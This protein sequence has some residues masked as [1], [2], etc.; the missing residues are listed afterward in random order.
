MKTAQFRFN[1]EGVPGRFKSSKGWSPSTISR[2]LKNTKYIG[3]WIW[4]KTESRKDPKTGRLRRFPKP[5]SKWHIHKDENLRIIPQKLWDKV[6]KRLEKTRRT[7]PG[8]KN[9]RGFEGQNG[10]RVTHYPRELLSGA[11]VCAVCGGAIGK[12][13]G[14]AGG[15]YGCL[16]AGKGSCDNKLLV[17]RTVAERIIITALG[18]KLANTDNLSFV[19]KRVE[20]KVREM[21]SEV[22][23]KIHL[24]EIELSSEQRRVDN[25]VAYISEGRRSEAIAKALETVEKRVKELS[26]ELRI[27][28]GSK[29]RMFKAPPSEWI[30]YR[31]KRIQNI[32]ERRVGKSA[33][34]MRKLLGKIRLEPVTPDIG[35]PYLRAVSNLQPLALFEIK[36]GSDK[37]EPDDSNEPEDGSNS[38][39]WWRRRESNPRPKIPQQGFYVRSLLLVFRF[40]VLQQAEDPE[41]SSDVFRPLSRSKVRRLAISKRRSTFNPD[42]SDEA[43]ELPVY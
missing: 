36:A 16:N 3:K 18:D 2:I 35:K 5:E 12:R 4:N 9:K 38:L 21:H 32:L 6:Q 26:F 22:P 39:R 27:L 40:P 28:K 11:M 10:S 20:K 31:V 25:F 17:R 15:Y 8:G 1:N 24:K 7:W 19:L 13:S 14:K 42:D 43:N 34:I 33:I 23:E 37:A 29:D 41:T 30:E